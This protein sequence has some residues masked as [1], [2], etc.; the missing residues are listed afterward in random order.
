MLRTLLI[1][2]TLSA[3]AGC[4]RATPEQCDALCMRYNELGYWERFEKDAASLA[5]DA[6]EK[7]RAERQKAWDEIAKR[8]FDPGRENC[9]K[10]CRRSAKPDDIKCVEKAKTLAAAKDCLK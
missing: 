3:V 4:R 6:R 8:E 2:V 10:E 1:L 9:V 7:L 5:P